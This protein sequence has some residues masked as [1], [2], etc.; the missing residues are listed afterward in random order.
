MTARH[1]DTGAVQAVG[2]FWR[3]VERSRKTLVGKEVAAS[4]SILT[5]RAGC[6]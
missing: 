6:L 1:H 5:R 4:G 3:F 2:D